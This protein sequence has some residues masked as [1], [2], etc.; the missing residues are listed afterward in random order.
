MST[1]NK[2]GRTSPGI[3]RFECEA[4]AEMAAEMA[5]QAAENAVMDSAAPPTC[6][7]MTEHS[8]PSL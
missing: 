2:V 1:M 6:A 5:A 3:D 8:A 7:S 4:D